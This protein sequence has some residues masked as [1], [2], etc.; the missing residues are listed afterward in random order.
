M[1]ARAVAVV[2]LLATAVALIAADDDDVRARRPMPISRPTVARRPADARRRV[3]LGR[4]RGR[5]AIYVYEL[6]DPS[7]TRKVLVVGCIHGNETAGVA[8]LGRL[9]G[10]PPPPSVDLW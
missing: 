4:S 6:G 3:L 10:D 9:A 1:I 5:G 8:V 7:T 2:A